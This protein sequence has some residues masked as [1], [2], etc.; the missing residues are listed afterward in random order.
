[1]TGAFSGRGSMMLASATFTGGLRDFFGRLPGAFLD[2][3]DQ[4]VLL[5][6]DKL[7]I[8]GSELGEFLFQ[9]AFGDV[10]VPFDCESAHNI[11]LVL[12]V[13]IAPS[14]VTKFLFASGV[15]R[16]LNP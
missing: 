1:L 6:A 12:L 8:V 4:L 14:D 16:R 10:P 7:L 15:P 3:T 5:A 13:S 2:A 11:I 9:L